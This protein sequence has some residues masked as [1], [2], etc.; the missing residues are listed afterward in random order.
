[1]PTYTENQSRAEA[2]VRMTWPQYRRGECSA[3][4]TVKL[5]RMETEM[6]STL[7]ARRPAPLTTG[8]LI[9][10]IYPDPDAE[11]EFAVNLTRRLIVSLRRKLGRHYITLSPRGY[12]IAA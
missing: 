9:E 6:L 4:V 7:L 5:T 2:I 3:L 12:R 11:P 8:D 10:A 1:M